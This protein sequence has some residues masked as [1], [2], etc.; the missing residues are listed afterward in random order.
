MEEKKYQVQ[1]WP[2]AIKEK[3]ISGDT[4]LLYAC[5]KR[6]PLEVVAASL[7]KWPDAVKEK[8]LSGWTPLHY[9]CYYK[10]R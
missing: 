2:D 6:A 5:L 9:A 4:P 7:Q 10:A 3:G 8:G 1:V